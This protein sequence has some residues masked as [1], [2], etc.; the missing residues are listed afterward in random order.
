[1]DED[2]VIASSVLVGCAGSVRRQVERLVCE[3]YIINRPAAVADPLS[4]FDT[5]VSR[6]RHTCAGLM[7]PDIACVTGYCLLFKA[8]VLLTYPAWESVL[9]WWT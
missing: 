8:D 6:V 3:G 1:M 7:V 5:V 9:D 2:G 4:V